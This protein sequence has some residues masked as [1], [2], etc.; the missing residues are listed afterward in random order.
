MV[1]SRN[2]WKR[3]GKKGHAGENTKE[4]ITKEWSEKR[5]RVNEAEME[6]GKANGHSIL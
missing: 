5:K 2:K 6:R 3:M 1:K 4:K